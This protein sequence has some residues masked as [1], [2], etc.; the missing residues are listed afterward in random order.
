MAKNLSPRAHKLI[1][2][3]AQEEG[4]LGGS[5]QLLPEHVLIALLKK[6]D[7]LGY[8][9]LQ[10]LHIN[11]LTFQL[12]LEQSLTLQGRDVTLD[13]LPASRRLRTMLDAASIE[14]RSLRKE[15]IGT[16]H[17]VIAAIREQYSVTARFFEKASI[18]I[19]DVY[20][21]VLQIYEKLQSSYDNQ[22]VKAMANSFFDSVNH[23][24]QQDKGQNAQSFLAEFSRDLTSL[25][26]SQQ[27]DPVVGRDKE[28]LRVVQI[29]SRR[30][31][32]N[33]VLLGE[34]GVGKTAIIEGLAQRIVLGQVP[35]NLLKKKI[36]AL[37]LGSVVAG[38]KY[39]GEFEERI[40]RIVKE[41]SDKK[42]I[43][44][45]IDELHTLIGAGGAEGT[46]DASNLL[47][48]ALAR[49]ELQCI[50]ATTLSE[51]RKYFE[52]DAALER[53]FQSV[54]VEEPTDLESIQILEGLK[55]R[56]EDFHGVR[57]E[58]DVIPTA[59]RF[60]RRYITDRCLPDKAIDILDEAGAM[61][62]II[63]DDK[64]SELDTLE[65]NIAQ[66]S[67]EKKLMVQNQDYEGAAEIRDKV[68][69]LKNQLEILRDKWE[70]NDLSGIKTV[71]T[72]DVCTVIANM[73]GIPL[74]QLTDS[75]LV[76][77]LR[78]EE[79]LHKSVIGQKEAVTS[80]TSAI[81]RARTGVSS[82]RRPAG[83]F[84]FLVPTGV[85][86]TLLAKTL[87]QYLFGKEDALI[88]VDMSD[89]MEKHNSSR[90]VGAPPGY[91]GFEEGGVLTEKVRRH[92]YSVVLLDEIEKAHPDVFNLLLQILE[93]GELTD[94]L[95]HTVNF[96][97]TVIIMTS[98]AGIRQITETSPLGF[99]LTERGTPSYE[100]IKEGALTELK[101]I[102]SPELLNRIDDTIVFTA[103]T[104]K[105]VER[106]LEIQLQELET[107]LSEKE[108]TLSVKPG[109]KKYLAEKGYD[110]LL[111]ARPMRRL[112][113]REIEDRL[114]VC[115]IE[116]GIKNPDTRGNKAVVDFVKDAI[117]VT[118]T[119]SKHKKEAKSE[120]IPSETDKTL[121]PV[122]DIETVNV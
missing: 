16:E 82:S 35:R 117:K 37:D 109:A 81:R 39:R 60:A 85:G 17:L 96:R 104:P 101:K 56:Y 65:K 13:E 54:L 33:P 24:M 63:E 116:E 28:I 41:V 66:L 21:A 59:V 79:E 6:G 97:N 12:A 112:I 11:V 87:A 14:S 52:K 99:S 67:E 122:E 3:Y 103:L 90:L 20:G 105:D 30:T 76:K 86:K 110:P 83:S 119:K 26:S 106:I 50:G 71:T 62:K 49:G 88:R 77:L 108:L 115:L 94:N 75:E 32:N 55:K 48:P 70:H 36:I 118:I 38:T 80:I 113:Q 114:A 84:I 40:K 51:Y 78:M 121:P 93:E 29:L 100:T 69:L 111:G 120:A 7:G 1:T 72:K 45:F 64:P 73:T 46:M 23:T 25:A 5:D 31:K 10:K 74:E 44:L 4:K 18:T 57:Y 95:G 22:K 34:P 15:Y 9:L 89:Y 19:D 42:D 68:H 92:P 2:I 47:K 98:N 53:R 91:V 102:L 43:I 58:Q 27:L 107:R 8:I 61:K